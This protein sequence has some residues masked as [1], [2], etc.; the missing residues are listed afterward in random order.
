MLAPQHAVSAVPH[1]APEPA[2]E[3]R[4]VG[5]GR[6]RV[7]GRHERFLDDVFRLTEVADEGQRITE[8]H[9][10]EA[11][12]EL[13]EG[14]EIA[15][16]RRPDRALQLHRSL[17]ANKCRDRPIGF[18]RPDAP[19]PP[20]GW[21]ILPAAMILIRNATLLDPAS[22]NLTENAS[23]VVEG[24]RI[25][26]VSPRPIQVSATLTL[27]AGGR[28]LMPG[29]IDCHVHVFLSE[30]NIRALEAI[31]LTLMTARGA[32]LM[33]A[34]LDRGFTTVR[35]TGGADWGIREGVAQ[36]LLPARRASSCAKVSTTS[37]SWCPAGWLRPTIR[38]RACSTRRTRSARRWR[39]RRSSSATCARTP[40]RPR[41]SRE[42]CRPACA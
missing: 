23:V 38:S 27:D 19:G 10:L 3:R 35:D 32:A 13:G 6:Q 26:E 41:R 14:V 25:R 7:P 1:D 17:L 11:P 4:R 22:G 36:G 12:G 40:T 37:R 2:G 21:S 28:T 18:T 33:R 5:Q 16:S 15:S 29:L 42:R 39:R 8:G 9:V 24:E 34:M 31:P 20:G 30:V